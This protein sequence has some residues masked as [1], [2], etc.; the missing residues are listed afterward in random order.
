MQINISLTNN[1]IKYEHNTN[2]NSKKCKQKIKCIFF[3]IKMYTKKL[4]E[5]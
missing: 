5:L 2:Q 3:N 1:Y 4:E